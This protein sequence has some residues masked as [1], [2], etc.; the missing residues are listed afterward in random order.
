[1]IDKKQINRGKIYK[2][3][4]WMNLGDE[5]GAIVLLSEVIKSAL[6]EDDDPIS[7]CEAQLFLAEIKQSSGNHEAARK[8]LDTVMGI[9]DERATEWRH[10]AASLIDSF[11]E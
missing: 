10:R 1:M 6:S 3:A 9:G 11:N 7:F 4:R 2:A 8:H 5:K